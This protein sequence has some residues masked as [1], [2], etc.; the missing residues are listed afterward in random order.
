M[1]AAL[2]AKGFTVEL[3][4]AGRLIPPAVLAAVIEPA[5]RRV[6]I[7]GAV[8][9]FREIA[10]AEEYDQPMAHWIPNVLEFSDCPRP[11]GHWVDGCRPRPGG[12]PI[13]FLAGDRFSTANSENSS[14]RLSETCAYSA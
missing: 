13:P 11:P 1:C 12:T 14:L 3:A 9:S 5:I 6:V 4:A 7:A 10:A 8:P 2:R